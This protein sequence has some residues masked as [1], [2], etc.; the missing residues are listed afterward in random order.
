MQADITIK[1]RAVV[2][3]NTN[4][5]GWAPQIEVTSR[6]PEIAVGRISGGWEL[7]GMDKE[8]AVDRACLMAAEEAARYSGDWLIVVEADTVF[9]DPTPTIQMPVRKGYDNA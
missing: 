3:T 4:S 9:V 5:P 8:A 7:R 6:G 1:Y 2:N